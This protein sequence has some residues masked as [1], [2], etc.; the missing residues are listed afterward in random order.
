[1]YGSDQQAAECAVFL[2]LQDGRSG[3]IDTEEG[4]EHCISRDELVKGVDLHCLACC[5]CLHRGLSANGTGLAYAACYGLSIDGA[6]GAMVPWLVTHSVNLPYSRSARQL[7]TDHTGHDIP[8]D[9]GTRIIITWQGVELD[10]IFGRSAV[11]SSSDNRISCACRNDDT[12]IHVAIVGHL[13]DDLLGILVLINSDLQLV[14][15]DLQSVD[16]RC[17]NRAAVLVAH[18]N[19]DS[20]LA[21]TAAEKVAKGQAYHRYKYQGNSEEQKE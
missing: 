8:Y 1:M 12:G 4:K 10:E 3:G 21:R 6:L 2:L 14:S 5:E 20:N 11:L 7:G 16:D 9:G 18:R 15:I 13:V 19:G 17:A